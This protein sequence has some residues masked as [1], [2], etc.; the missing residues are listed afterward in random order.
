MPC[1]FG[2]QVALVPRRRKR[3]I[4]S[5]DNKQ[6]EVRVCRKVEYFE[7]HILNWSKVADR[8]SSNSFGIEARYRSRGLNH[9]EDGAIVRGRS[10]ERG[11]ASKTD[12]DS[13]SYRQ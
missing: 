11:E 13:H 5:I 2:C 1:A 6:R 10:H 12:S 4:R 9:V 3:C 8:D 7:V